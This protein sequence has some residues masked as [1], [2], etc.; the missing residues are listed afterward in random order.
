MTKREDNPVER[1]LNFAD[2]VYRPSLAKNRSD[3][4]NDCINALMDAYTSYGVFT[5][6]EPQQFPA[7]KRLKYSY[8]KAFLF[9]LKGGSKGE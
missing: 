9:I 2:N 5:E 3:W 1:Y 6:A 4:V 8:E 7:C